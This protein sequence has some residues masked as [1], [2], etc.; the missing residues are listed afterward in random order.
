MRPTHYMLIAIALCAAPLHAQNL[1][2]NGEFDDSLIGWEASGDN[3]ILVS[4]TAAD[5]N[6]S[7]S[8]G[9]AFVANL[10]AGATNGV[11]LAQCVPV[12]S[13]QTYIISGKA[14]IPSAN[15]QVLT[16]KAV[17]SLRWY[18]GADCTIANGFDPLIILSEVPLLLP[19]GSA[20]ED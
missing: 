4:W 11:T 13:G 18:S 20:A 10:S 9:S 5:A 1:V 2:L 19:D 15:G 12:N 3:D 6:G 17:L 16:D 14:R 8:S 7:A